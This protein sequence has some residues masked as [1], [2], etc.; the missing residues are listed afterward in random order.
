M[1]GAGIV[2]EI[3]NHYNNDHE[4]YFKQTYGISSGPHHIRSFHRR[5]I[6]P[7]NLKNDK[8]DIIGFTRNVASKFTLNS[9]HTVYRKNG[10]IWV[11]P[12]VVLFGKS[13]LAIVY[14]SQYMHVG[15]PLTEA[16]NQLILK[17]IDKQL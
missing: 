12:E 14:N 5:A 1:N 3:T 7:H 8:F 15:E 11:E 4:I 6:Y 16:T 10:E 13:Q 2:T 17:L 9:C